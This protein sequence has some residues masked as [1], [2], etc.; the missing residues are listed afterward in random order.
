VGT[1]SNYPLV[2]GL[3]AI[4]MEAAAAPNM[5]DHNFIW[6]S[7][8]ANGIYGYS[9]CKMIVAHNLI[10][11]CGGAGIMILDVPGRGTIPVGDNRVFENILINNGWSIEFYSPNNFSDFNVLGR[12]RRLRAYHFNVTVANP[13]SALGR[14]EELN[15]ADWRRQHGFDQHSSE[16]NIMAEFNPDTLELVWSVQGEFSEGPPLEGMRYDFWNRSESGRTGV[17]G[18]FGRIPRETTRVTVDPRLPGDQT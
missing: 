16:V 2:R 5:I 14:S 10:G 9:S 18:P 13:L 11:N 1:G 8:L 3:G 6:D 12:A 17:A 4:M 7:T 15:L